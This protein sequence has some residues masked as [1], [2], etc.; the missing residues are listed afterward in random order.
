MPTR[1]KKP[2]PWFKTNAQVRERMKESAKR[3]MGESLKEN[4]QFQDVAALADGTL[5]FGHRRLAG[6][7]L[8]GLPDLW[9][10]VYDEPLTAAEITGMQLVENIQREDLT[11][12][13]QWRGCVKLL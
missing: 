13:E 3:E 9:V 8:I 2:L 10:Q 5:I 4:G 1:M 7:E 12:F 6:A 11:G